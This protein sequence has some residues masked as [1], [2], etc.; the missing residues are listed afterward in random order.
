MIA[1]NDS[2]GIETQEEHVSGQGMGGGGGGKEG[3]GEAARKASQP[4]LE[5]QRWERMGYHR[6]L[7][8]QALPPSALVQSGRCSG[9]VGL[10][11][12]GRGPLR[13]RPSRRG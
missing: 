6:W 4:L 8:M 7:M 5:R 1:C 12:Y 9:S 11:E 13:C 2:M 10:T 3:G